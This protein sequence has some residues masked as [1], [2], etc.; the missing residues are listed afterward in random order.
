MSDSTFVESNLNVNLLL[1]LSRSCAFTKG[2][3]DVRASTKVQ[4]YMLHGL[5]E[6]VGMVIDRPLGSIISNNP[7]L[8]IHV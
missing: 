6:T 1:K 8:I 3:S 4:V 7:K 2:E 5:L